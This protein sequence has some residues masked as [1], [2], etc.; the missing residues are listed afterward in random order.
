MDI[1]GQLHSSAIF[2]PGKKFWYPLNRRLNGHPEAGL[3]VLQ[4][5]RKHILLPGFETWIIH[6]VTYSTLSE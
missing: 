3:D 6:S 2:P 4:T 1:S 5:N